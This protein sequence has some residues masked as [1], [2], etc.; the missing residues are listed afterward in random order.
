MID[1]IARALNEEIRF[2]HRLYGRKGEGMDQE[3]VP[4]N[5]SSEHINAMLRIEINENDLGDFIMEAERSGFLVS[6]RLFGDKPGPVT[7]MNVTAYVV[8]N[9]PARWR[10]IN[11]MK[12]ARR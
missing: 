12:A 8:R 10:V 5:L 1:E 3:M 11:P 6:D 4:L 7:F 2:T 9:L